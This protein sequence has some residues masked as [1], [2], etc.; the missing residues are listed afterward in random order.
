ML[1]SEACS[2]AKWFW[3]KIFCIISTQVTW[4]SLSEWIL[5]A[6]RQ[7]GGDFKSGRGPKIGFRRKTSNCICTYCF[8]YSRILPENVDVN[9]NR[10]KVQGTNITLRAKICCAFSGWERA[11][12]KNGIGGICWPNIWLDAEIVHRIIT[13]EMSSIVHIHEPRLI[14]SVIIFPP[15]LWS[16]LLSNRYGFLPCQLPKV[17]A[18]LPISYIVLISQIS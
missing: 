8:H 11:A 15:K 2:S 10:Y 6:G 9:S 1:A 18:M 13:R 7:T 4:M 5:M 14:L 17:R 16:I 12:V 3:W